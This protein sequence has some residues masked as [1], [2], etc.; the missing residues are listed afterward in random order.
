VYRALVEE[1]QLWDVTD[2]VIFWAISKE[3]MLLTLTE[4]DRLLALME[5]VQLQ[6]NELWDYEG[7]LALAGH[8]DVA[9][10]VG[11]LP[12][13]EGDVLQAISALR[14][15]KYQM[16]L[17]LLGEG[18]APVALFRVGLVSRVLHKAIQNFGGLYDKVA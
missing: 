12:V 2:N 1:Y 18:S 8:Q 17:M 13:A 14:L 5:E 16:V 11:L 3:D 7:G 9:E 15:S 10:E 4:E 6:E